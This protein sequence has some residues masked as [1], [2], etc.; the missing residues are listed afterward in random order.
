MAENSFSEN[1]LEEVVQNTFFSSTQRRLPLKDT[2]SLIQGIA[3]LSGLI[4]DFLASPETVCQD[5]FESDSPSEFVYLPCFTVELRNILKSKKYFVSP[6]IIGFSFK[7]A[8]KVLKHYPVLIAV[9]PEKLGEFTTHRGVMIFDVDTVKLDDAIVRVLTSQRADSGGMESIQ[10]IVKEEFPSATVHS[11]AEV[12]GNSSPAKIA[13]S[14]NCPLC[15][16]QQLMRCRCSIGDLTCVNGHHYHESGM[17]MKVPADGSHPK[18]KISV[19]E[20]LSSRKHAQLQVLQKYIVNIEALGIKN[21][22]H[23]AGSP[24]EAVQNALNKAWQQSGNPHK[25][26]DFSVETYKASPFWPMIVRQAKRDLPLTYNT[27]LKT[28]QVTQKGP[29][30]PVIELTPTEQKIF[31]FILNINQKYNLGLTFRVA[32][33]WVRDKVLGKESDDIDIALDKMTGAQFG[34]FL[35]KEIG[36]GGNV[37]KA[38]PDQSKHLETMTIKLFGQD[39]DF[40][41][42]RSET[43]GDSRIPEMQFGAPDQDADRRDLTINALFYNVNTS[44]VEDFTGKGIQDLQTMTLRTPLDPKKTFMDDP[45][46]ILRLLRFFSRYQKSNVDPAALAAMKDPEVQRALKT[47]VSPER[48]ATELKKLME[49]D[50][51]EEASRLLKQTGLL[52]LIT[53]VPEAAGFHDF[54]MDQHNPHHIDNVFEHTLR[55]MKELNALAR[56]NNVPSERRALM[57]FAALFHDIGKLCPDVIG[58]KQMTGVI[59][60]L[61]KEEVPVSSNFPKHQTYHGHEDVSAKVVRSIMEKLKMSNDEINYVVTLVQEHMKPHMG[62]KHWTDKNIRKYLNQFGEMWVDIFNHAVADAKSKGDTPEVQNDLA[63]KQDI[64]GRMKNMP[65]SPPKPVL[66]GRAL[67]GMFPDLDPSSGFIKDI[68]TRLMDIQFTQPQL[69]PEEATQLVNGMA[70][71]IRSKYAPLGKKKGPLMKQPQPQPPTPPIQASVEHERE[72]GASGNP[73]AWLERTKAKMDGEPSTAGDLNAWYKRVKT[74][75]DTADWICGHVVRKPFGTGSKSES[76]QNYLIL[77]DGTGEYVLRRSNGPAFGDK[78][79]DELNGKSICCKGTIHQHLFII[80]DYEVQTE[81]DTEDITFMA[82]K[83]PSDM[84]KFDVG[85]RVRRRGKGLAFPQLSGKVQRIEGDLMFI[86][87]DGINELEAVRLTDTVAL[88]GTIERA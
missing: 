29:K 76:L 86:K 19:Q 37:I 75:R 25:A 43:Y 18:E 60:E 22:V 28:A 88:Y 40:V 73:N 72:P 32:G 45:L 20:Y 79:L 85:T 17:M 66:D 12:P 71:E 16:G 31:S 68:H 26:A 8:R 7:A 64:M 5:I 1:P 14:P 58:V 21:E 54:E 59:D 3:S 4:N 77:G 82:R 39:V 33:G 6:H 15:G 78:V 69:T 62:K 57:L 51:P 81:G 35:K 49:G 48:I 80:S 83:S 55:V 63:E 52:S 41:N 34:E 10:K 65:P 24:E 50:K 42:L 56:A 46:R 2:K 11:F 84:A 74:A 47:K 61:G 27:S 9:D 23:K 53:D 44:Q 30:M 87:W 67:M 70:A 36:K 38:N 13:S